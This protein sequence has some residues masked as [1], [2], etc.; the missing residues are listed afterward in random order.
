MPYRASGVLMALGGLVAVAGLVIVGID[1][2]A[3]SKRGPRWKRRLLGAGLA[4]LGMAGVGTGA[5]AGRPPQVTCYKPAPPPF[6]TPS[7]QRLDQQAFLLGELLE[8][9]KLDPEVARKALA[10]A[11]AALAEASRQEVIEAIPP[12]ERVRAEHLRMLARKSMEEAR[13]KLEG[14]GQ[15]AADLAEDSGWPFLVAA[16]GEAEEVASGRRGQYPFDEAGKSWLLSMIESA[17]RVPGQLAQ[18]GLLSEA[19]GALLEKD[20]AE[21]RREVEA[22]HTKE[23]RNATCCDTVAVIPARESAARLASKLPLLEKMASEGKLNPATAGKVL[24][25]VERDLAT[26][27]REQELKQLSTAERSGAEKTRD[28]VKAQVETLKK[29]TA[30]APKP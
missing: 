14:G 16:W 22:K 4:L 21:L 8:N 24:A 15:Q 11:E 9:G 10:A 27:G 19:E 7:L 23:M 28:A 25:A 29:L 12:V 30:A 20:L 17:A 5:A 18:K 13:I 3:A 6:T 26:L 2:Y 1:V